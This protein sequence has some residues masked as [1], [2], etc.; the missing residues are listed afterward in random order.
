MYTV[1]TQHGQALLFGL[2]A[3]YTSSTHPSPS[4]AVIALCK[5]SICSKCTTAINTTLKGPVVSSLA[6]FFLYLRGS[7]NRP[8]KYVK[9]KKIIVASMY[10]TK[11]MPGITGD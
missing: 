1:D 9:E 6:R 2:Y 4:Q 3:D 10:I 11:K 7:A 5:C 8:Y